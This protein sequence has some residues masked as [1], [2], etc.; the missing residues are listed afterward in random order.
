M[1]PVISV[2]LAALLACT[3]QSCQAVEK[4]NSDI[5]AA[6]NPERG[7]V[8][9]RSEQNLRLRTQARAYAERLDRGRC[10]MGREKAD[11]ENALIAVESSVPALR[12]AG[13]G[14][15]VVDDAQLA[16][17]T[18]Q[19]LAEARLD[20]A[21]AARTGGCSEIASSQ[22]QA[23]VRAFR[24]P[25]FAKYRQRAEIGLSALQL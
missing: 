1:R 6:P 9:S 3:L 5:A 24:G 21:D 14:S 10:D 19:A 18:E 16:A 20:V 23:V 12:N 7:V 22:Y 25:T 11:F 8:T 4:A 2:G 13:T 17:E 15:P